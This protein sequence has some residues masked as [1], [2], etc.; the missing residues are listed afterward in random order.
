MEVGNRRGWKDGHKEFGGYGD[1][2]LEVEEE[3]ADLAG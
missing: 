2:S 1:V 3:E